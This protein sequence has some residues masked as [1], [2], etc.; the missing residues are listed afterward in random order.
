METLQDSAAQSLLALSKSS[1]VDNNNNNNN[2]RGAGTHTVDTPHV[3]V[4]L[5]H[6]NDRVSGLTVNEWPSVTLITKDHILM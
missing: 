1:G 5:K 6:L 3:Y 2:N 4:R